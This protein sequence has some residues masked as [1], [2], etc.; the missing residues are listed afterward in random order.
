MSRY[1]SREVTGGDIWMSE[2]SVCSLKLLRLVQVARNTKASALEMNDK[3][4][5]VM[6]FQ[7]LGGL[8]ASGQAAGNRKIPL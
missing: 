1:G 5:V 4:A 3:L 6:V 7:Q 2:R 8:W